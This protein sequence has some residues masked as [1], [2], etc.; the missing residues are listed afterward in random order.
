MVWRA[1]LS[2]GIRLWHQGCN[3][4]AP[5]ILDWTTGATRAQWQQ[6][7]YPGLQ[8]QET[9][10]QDTRR[11]SNIHCNR[12][13]GGGYLCSFPWCP[14]QYWAS[15]LSRGIA[16]SEGLCRKPTIRGKTWAHVYQRAYLSSRFTGSETGYPS[17]TKRFK[18]CIDFLHR[19]GSGNAVLSWRI[20]SPCLLGN[21]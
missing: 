17:N 7:T 21:T 8:L 2:C 20:K 16:S 6:E 19:H 14:W 10:T 12:C 18:R 4:R 15:P 9:G 11:Y 5:A 1:H 3:G 13:K